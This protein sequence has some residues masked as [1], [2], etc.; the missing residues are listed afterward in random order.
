MQRETKFEIVNKE[1]QEEEE[2][3]QNRIVLKLQLIIMKPKIKKHNLSERIASKEVPVKLKKHEK[4]KKYIVEFNRSNFKF[5][6]LW[7]WKLILSFAEITT[8]FYEARLNNEEI[9]NPNHFQV[10][11]CFFNFHEDRIEYLVK[12]HYAQAK[13]IKVRIIKI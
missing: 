4:E 10:Q 11:H 9:S 3:D 13:T 5:F 8:K 6:S 7:I 2:E 12:I 1:E